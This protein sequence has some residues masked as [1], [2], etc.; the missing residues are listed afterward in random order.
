MWLLLETIPTSQVRFK[1]WSCKTKCFKLH[2]HLLPII[3]GEINNKSLL[4]EL[5][6]NHLDKTVKAFCLSPIAARTIHEDR[7]FSLLK[8]VRWESSFMDSILQC[9]IT[10]ITWLDQKYFACAVNYGLSQTMI[11][12]NKKI[13]LMSFSQWMA[14]QTISY[15]LDFFSRGSKLYAQK[16]SSWTDSPSSVCILSFCTIVFLY[17]CLFVLSS[18]WR[19][20]PAYGRQGLNW[21]VGSG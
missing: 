17:Y 4:L 20:K 11:H 10:N 6:Q 2:N 15:F 3:N 5:A 14:A 9:L 7:E 1:I 19:P 18:F 16:I 21:I 12:C 13:L 8:I